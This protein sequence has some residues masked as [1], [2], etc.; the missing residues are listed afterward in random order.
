MAKK[1]SSLNQNRVGLVTVSLLMV[2]FL[3]WSVRSCSDERAE[4]AMIA[5]EEARQNYL[6]SLQQAEDSLRIVSAAEA[7]AQARAD[8]LRRAATTPPLGDSVV[9]AP[10]ERII[11]EQVTV[12]YVTFEG[13]NV[14]KG[15]GLNYGKVDRLSLYDEVVF[16]NEVTDSSYQINLGEITPNEP[17]I[18]VRTPAGKIGWVYGAG[19]D[20]FKRQLLGVDN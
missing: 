6:D 12:L 16:L 14:R 1:K 4:Y 7:E 3:I 5:E 9:R 11:R 13:L 20:Y 18:K 19:V 17:W 2:L 15:P 10:G 8:A